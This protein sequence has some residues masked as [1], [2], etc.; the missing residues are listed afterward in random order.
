MLMIQIIQ[1]L[2]DHEHEHP[3]LWILLTDNPSS[4]AAQ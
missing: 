3:Y 2:L 1:Q 4:I